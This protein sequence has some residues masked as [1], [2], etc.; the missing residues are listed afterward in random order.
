MANI[1]EVC[2]GS[3][4]SV[5]AARRGG[6]ARIELCSALAEGG[7]TPS[8]GLIRAAV[9]V[10]GI[11]KHVLI[12]PRGGDFLY[13]EEEQRI[14]ADDIRTARELGADGVVVG[15]LTADGRIDLPAMERFMEAA[16]GMSVTFHRAFDLCR[17]PA[18]ALEDIVRLGCHRIL[19]SGQAPTAEQGIPLLRSLVQQAAGRI[20]ILP[21]GGVGAGNAARILSATGAVELHASAR[22]LW[23][24]PMRFRHPGVAMGAPGSD[25]Y[26]WMETSAQCVRDILASIS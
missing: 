2:A 20:G 21:G 26:S 25:E 22:S 6:A 13:A 9:G 5:L 7:V 4:A 8:L 15:A 11:R 10:E 24:S 12:R 1:L 23:Q 19:T 17:D 14:M 16:Q 3:Y 18:E